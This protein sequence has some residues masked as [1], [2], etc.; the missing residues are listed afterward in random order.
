MVALSVCLDRFDWPTRD[1]A[2][3][4]DSL[5]CVI[6]PNA[7]IPFKAGYRYEGGREL[8]GLLRSELFD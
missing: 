7:G 6:L 3:I 4:D 1:R 2:E 8:V 5:Q